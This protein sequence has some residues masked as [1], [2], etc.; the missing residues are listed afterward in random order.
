MDH[1]DC[2][3]PN[4][5]DI[6]VEFNNSME[7]SHMVQKVLTCFYCFELTDGRVAFEVLNDKHS[8]IL[9]LIMDQNIVKPD[10][11]TKSQL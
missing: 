1:G 4:G 5:H 8:V 2:Y 11:K 9:V 10:F 3:K 6:I 7:F